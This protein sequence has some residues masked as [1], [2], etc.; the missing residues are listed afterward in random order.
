MKPD[1]SSSSLLSPGRGRCRRSQISRSITA[2]SDSGRQCAPVRRRAAAC[3]AEERSRCVPSAEG[4]AVAPSVIGAAEGASERGIA[5]ARAKPKAPGA[6]DASRGAAIGTRRRSAQRHVMTASGVGRESGAG[7]GP[8]HRAVKRDWRSPTL[9]IRVWAAGKVEGERA[10]A[11]PRNLWPLCRR[12]PCVK[13]AHAPTTSSTLA[14]SQ[15]AYP[16]M[17]GDVLGFRLA[18]GH[19]FNFT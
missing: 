16:G 4:I 8:R 5:S 10:A 19:S 3:G 12:H 13:E 11:T 7:E 18:D 15:V 9:P 14:G 1:G 17:R 2:A 6:R